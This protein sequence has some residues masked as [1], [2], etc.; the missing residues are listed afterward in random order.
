MRA[1]CEPPAAR[2]L[3]LRYRD[4]FLVEVG[5][6]RG[7]REWP[8]G[9]DRPADSDSGPIVLGIGVAASGIG[10]GATRALG[11]VDDWKALERSAHLAGM[12]WLADRGP[13]LT[14]AMTLWA[15][16]ARPWCKM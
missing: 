10:L 6:V 15:E 3:Y 8:P 11:A 9:V 1:L 16:G 4:R 7:F 13:R 2:R 12:G 14:R 5:P